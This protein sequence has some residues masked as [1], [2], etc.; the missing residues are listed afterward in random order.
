MIK[1]HIPALAT[2]AALLAAPSFADTLRLRSLWQDGDRR[3]VHTGLLSRAE[4]ER[5]AE[6]LLADGLRLIDVETEVVNGRRGYMGLWAEGTGGNFFFVGGDLN[7][8]RA[9]MEEM[10]RTGLRLLDFEVFRDGA[11]LRYI[12]VFGPGRGREM[13]VR[14][15]PIA[16]FLEPKDLMRTLGMQL[17]DVEPIGVSGRWRFAGLYASEAPPAVFTG[18]R[19]RSR[20]TELRDRMVSDGWELFDFERVPNADGD[21]V[22]IGLWREDDGASRI[23]RFRS[24][25]EQLLFTAQQLADGATP[26]DNGDSKRRRPAAF[27]QNLFQRPFD[28]V[29]HAAPGTFHQFK[30]GQLARLDR[31]PL[32]RAHLRGRQQFCLALRPLD[33]KLITF[34]ACRTKNHPKNRI[35]RPARLRVTLANCSCE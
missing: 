33:S 29:D 12:G 32:D 4:F 14:P 7:A 2:V 1:L 15:L 24:A 27:C 5:R 19:P 22:Y 17:R 31:S 35:P 11:R 28:R 21:D 34:C 8:L 26:T 20:F 3:A 18:F 16:Q 23:S 13:M 9:R 6:A 10:R 25:S 30:A